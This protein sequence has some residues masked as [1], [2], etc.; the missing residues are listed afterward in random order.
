MVI[1]CNW[2]R[3]NWLDIIPSSTR[4][5]GIKPLVFMGEISFSM[6]RQHIPGAY[7]CYSL[8]SINPQSPQ[9]RSS[10]VGTLSECTLCHLD[11][12]GY[13]EARY[14]SGEEHWKL[15]GEQMEACLI[16]EAEQKPI[17]LHFERVVIIPITKIRDFRIRE[18]LGSTC[19][20][21]TG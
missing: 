9:R 17:K 11:L 1:P 15:A 13:R 16:H 4:I 5:L 19:Q 8:H 14:A 21:S 2:S 18:D 7:V 20:S 6:S 10:L 12:L 3:R